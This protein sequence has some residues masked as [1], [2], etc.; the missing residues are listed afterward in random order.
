MGKTQNENDKGLT[1]LSSAEKDII[2]LQY[3]KKIKKR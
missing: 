3:P 1:P 2:P